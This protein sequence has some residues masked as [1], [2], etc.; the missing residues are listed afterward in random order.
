MKIWKKLFIPFVVGCALLLYTYALTVSSTNI[1]VT[2]DEAIRVLQAKQFASGTPKLF[3]WTQP[4]Q[5]PL[6]SLIE[7]PVVNMLPRNGLGARL[8][9]YLME[10]ASI[11]LLLIALRRQS[12]FKDCWPGC[13]LLL[14]PSAY[15]LMSRFGYPMLGYTSITLLWSLAI[16]LAT[17]ECGNAS[18]RAILVVMLNGFVCGLAY[19]NNMLALAVVLPIAIVVCLGS[20]FR[21]MLLRLPA[22]ALGCLFGLFPYLFGIWRYPEARSVVSTTR[23]LRETLARLWTPAL[24]ETLPRALGA[25]PGLFPDSHHTLGQPQWMVA[26]MA[27][28]FVAILLVATCSCLF[29]QSR[30]LLA[31]Q[32]PQ[33]GLHEI[34]LGSSWLGLIMFAASTRAD[35]ASY[36]Y[37]LP[38]AWCFPLLVYC[39]FTSLPARAR[40]LL[41]AVVVCI[42]LFN[43]GTTFALVEQWKNPAYGRDIVNAPDL[44]PTLEFLEEKGIRY[45]VASH[46]AAYRIN[47][48]SDESIKCSQPMNERFP[49]WPI[50]YKEE[51]DAQTNVAYVLTE[52]IRFLK[53]SI[54]ERHLDTMEVSCKHASRGDFE[55]Y[56]DFIQDDPPEYDRLVLDANMLVASENQSDVGGML[57]GD[58]HSFWRSERLQHADMWIQI[59]L[60]SAAQ[61]DRLLIYRGIYSQDNPRQLVVEKQ[62]GEGWEQVSYRTYD[63]WGDKFHFEKGHP[64]YGAPTVKTYLFD[65]LRATVLRISITEPRP[66]WA[67][68]ITE[69]DLRGS[70]ISEESRH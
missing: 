13:A 52:R 7:A 61:L 58:H 60:P 35:S 62:V 12:A 70:Y 40:T 54:F 55:I 30:R 3:L 65:E 16:W 31:K 67:W 8:P 17:L 49:G 9:S 34:A 47:F 2:S 46:W 66:S 22:F 32:W 33:L 27:W 4:Y 29:R 42:V 48:L 36:R 1:P 63:D 23:P 18:K 15:I 45:C 37:L 44:R 69:L 19:T 26:A 64:V 41:A 24:A 14:F 68:T 43:V 11:A 51:V 5:F 28:F 38:V 25:D 59:E 39:A 21:S 53:P 50:P 10:F 6:Q 56:Y 20:R 57:D